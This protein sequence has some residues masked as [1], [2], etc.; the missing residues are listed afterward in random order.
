M[1]VVF[2]ALKEELS[3]LLGELVS[4]GL[5]GIEVYYYSHSMEETERYLSLASRYDLAVTGGSDFHGPGM[6]ETRLGVGRGNMNIP[7]S[8]AD[9]L[10]RL[11]Q[12]GSP[13]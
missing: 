11:H 8:V 9:E 7:R 12:E 5:A 6:I 2:F 10:T 4:F 13:R 1:T 3:D